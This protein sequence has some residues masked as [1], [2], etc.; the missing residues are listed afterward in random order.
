[1]VYNADFWESNPIQKKRR[2][3]RSKNLG[4]GLNNK[5]VQCIQRSNYNKF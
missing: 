5:L 3:K 4:D 2:E 1:M